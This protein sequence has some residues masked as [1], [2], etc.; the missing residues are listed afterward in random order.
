M[1][2]QVFTVAKVS[3]QVHGNFIAHARQVTTRETLE[4][5]NKAAAKVWQEMQEEFKERPDFGDGA[6]MGESVIIFDQDGNY[7]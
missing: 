1:K 4:D 6:I 7:Y 5:A 3:D 2:K